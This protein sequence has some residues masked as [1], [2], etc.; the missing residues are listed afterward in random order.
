M[1][2]RELTLTIDEA[3]IARAHA[4]SEAR[5][6]SISQL[7]TEYLDRLES[8]SASGPEAYTPTVRRLLGVLPSDTSRG[9]YRRHLAEKYDPPVR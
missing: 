4:Y 6:T 1:A 2:K 9:D 7:V 5:R 3:V 8:A